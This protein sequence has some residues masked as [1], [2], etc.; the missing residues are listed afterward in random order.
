MLEKSLKSYFET[1]HAPVSDIYK[2]L[3]LYTKMLKEKIMK[4]LMGR[5]N[6]ML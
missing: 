6:Y 1:E 4:I 3:T 2:L 5:K